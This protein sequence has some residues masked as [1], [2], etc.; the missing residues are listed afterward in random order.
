M[1]WARHLRLRLRTLFRGGRVEQELT[2]EFQYH[3]ERM[4][5]E[6]VHSGL[7]RSAARAQAL[8]DMGAINQRKEDCRDVSGL[9]M[10]HGL[11]QDLTYALRGLAHAPGF[12]GAA[13]LTLALGIGA[14][15]AVFSVVNTVL[16][17]PL[18]YKDADQLVRVVERAAPQGPNGPVA[19]RITMTWAELGQWRQSSSTLSD[20]V[21]TVSPPI[22]LMPTSSG[23]AR[24]T[25]ALVS[26]NMFA[27]LG[28]TARL[29]RTLDQQDDVAGA[30]TV[31]ISSAAWQK[32]FQGD[33]G[34]VGRTMTLKTFGP[35]AGFLDGTPLVVVGVMPEGF[36]FPILNCDFWAPLSEG[37]PAR[38]KQ[39]GNVIARRRDGI[40]MQ[41]ANDEANVIGEALRPKP[42]SGPLANPLPS[43]MRR[44]DVEGIKEQMIAPNR[45]ALRVL[46]IAVSAVLLIVCANIVSLLLARGSARQRE[47]ALRL[48]IGASRGRLIRQFLTESA[49]LAA[50]GGAFGVLVSIGGV[51]FLR[52][53]GSPNAPGPFRISFGGAMLPRLNEVHADAKLLVLAILLTGLTAMLVGIVPALRGS[54]V[55]QAHAMNQRGATGQTGA[56]RGGLG[57]RDALVVGQ[58]GIAIILLIGAGLL[59]NSFGKLSRLDP[60]W[61]ASGVLNFYLVMPQDYPT[62]RKAAL[63]ENVLSELARIPEVR[64]AGFTYAGPLLGLIDT[65][66]VFVPQGRTVDEMRDRPDTPHIRA[67]SH[68]YLQTMGVR[69]LAGRWFEARD[70]ALAPPVIIVN[71]TV[72]RRFFNDENPVGQMVHLDG[73]MDQPPQKIIGVVDDMRQG[74]LDQDPA[75]QLFVDYRQM[76]ALTQARNLPTAVQERLA[77]GFYSFVVRTDRD[78]ATLSPAVRSLIVRV[79]STAGIDAMLPMEEL[80]SASLTRQRFYALL[81]GIFAVIATVLGAV[82]IYGVLAYAVGQRTQEFGVRLAL[83]ARPRDILTLVLRRGILLTALGIVTGVA[84]AVAL[85]RYLRGM[86][87]E[88]TPL[89]PTTYLTVTLLFAAVALVAAYLP[90]RRATRLEA[91]VALRSE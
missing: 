3:L 78:P 58:L 56:R 64:S 83:G 54:R 32:Y 70:D 39:G 82:G 59:I 13:V 71:R 69:L 43:G 41:A 74:R 10:V 88:V 65:L 25:G 60:G 51:W 47:V 9:T 90:T 67:V 87:F 73:R 23:S 17:E 14:T 31:V 40:S 62:V 19:R 42:T 46:A 80:V 89:D 29:G 52:E 49:V 6:Y 11:R 5:D 35:E 72:M 27:F 45:Q 75:P 86:L 1:R 48:A 77:L 20:F 79:D 34:I 16:L 37:S 61:N 38:T 18:P 26:S 85:T 57:L 36:D 66:G 28:V 63:V 12:T 68:D 44:F 7:P 30:D 24:L 21:Y 8:R 55:G 84:G 15:T 76:L 53:F 2:E 4:I 50:I 81:P 91:A 22:T 33:P